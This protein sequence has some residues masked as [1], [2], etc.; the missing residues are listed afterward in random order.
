MHITEPMALGALSATKSRTDMTSPAALSD[1]RPKTSVS[2]PAA[3]SDSRPEVTNTR[4][5][6]SGIEA[7]AEIVVYTARYMCS[8]LDAGDTPASAPITSTAPPTSPARLGA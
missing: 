1:V 7:I 2:R 3:A 4:R 8:R 5:A 6:S